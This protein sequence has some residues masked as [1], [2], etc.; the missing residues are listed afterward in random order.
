MENKVY[1][2][3]FLGPR[4][5][6]SEAAA[7]R[8]SEGKRYQLVECSSLESIFSEVA[9]G[10]L[11]EGIVPVENSIGGIVGIVADLLAGHFD[12]TVRGEAILPVVH[13]LL[14]WPGVCMQDIEKVLSHPQAI[15]QCRLFLRKELPDAG[16][17]ECSSTAAAAV[18]VARTVHPWAAL[19]P[20]AAACVYNLDVLA[21]EVND[22][23]HNVTRFLAI[24][25]EHHR[26]KL[27]G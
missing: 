12:L 13:S 23:S 10:M 7:C 11:E 21:R 18:M 3:G 1:R 8:Y 14:V 26:I 15:A 27:L 16:W 19:A 17:Q 22:S 4:G 25:K 9:S 20:A 2:L 5:T 24:G 6:F